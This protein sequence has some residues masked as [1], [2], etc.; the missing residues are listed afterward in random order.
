MVPEKRNENMRSILRAS[1]VAAAALAA[2]A[3]AGVSSAQAAGFSIGVGPGG[4][5]FSVSSGGYCDDRGCP[6]AF[7]DMPV[8][9]CPVFY[10]GDWYRG[11]VYYRH[12]PDGNQYWIRGQWRF[13]AWRGPRPAWA[14]NDR[15]G[16]A[17][18]FDYYEKHGFHM[19]D[20]WRERWR[21][22]HGGPDRHGPGADPFHDRHSPD[23]APDRHGPDGFRDRDRGSDRDFHDR[24]DD[25]NRPEAGRS[26]KPQAGGPDKLKAGPDKQKAGPDKQKAGPDKQKAGPDKQGGSD[27]HEGKHEDKHDSH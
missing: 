7:W 15:F 1:I 23:V 6:D 16:P 14:C 26:D 5:N 24:R 2:G 22:D 27:K 21:R 10:H 11:P 17:L 8:Y 18:G 13:D 4:V 12:T 25:R 19:R 3:F 20:E 9:Y